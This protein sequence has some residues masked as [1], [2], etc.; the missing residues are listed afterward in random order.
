MPPKMSLL[1]T[2]LVAL[3]FIVL[4][5]CCL[6]AEIFEISIPAF[7]LFVVLVFAAKRLN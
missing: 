5:A 3:A 2:A 7:A 6:F 1:K 4:I